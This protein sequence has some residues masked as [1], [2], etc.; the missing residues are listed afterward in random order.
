MKKKQVNKKFAITIFI[1]LGYIFYILGIQQLQI[2]KQNKK[3]SENNNSIV[4]LEQE[5]KDLKKIRDKHN[6]DE[7][8]EK[9]AREK[10]GYVKPG[11]KIYIDMSKK[12]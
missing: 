10:L 12:Q 5:T 2:Y 7:F 9:I 4:K 11:E 3:I 8:I 1:G 6:T